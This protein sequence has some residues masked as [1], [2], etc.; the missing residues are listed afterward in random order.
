MFL[1]DHLVN[2]L[3]FRIGVVW[4]ITEQDLYGLWFSCE[5]FISHGHNE[6]FE[7]QPFPVNKI[8]VGSWYQKRRFLSLSTCSMTFQPSLL[9]GSYAARSGQASENRI[10]VSVFIVI[11]A[12]VE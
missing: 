11:V 4:T 7:I 5:I 12:I 8:L 2:G 10:A 6:R 3:W 1:I 9:M